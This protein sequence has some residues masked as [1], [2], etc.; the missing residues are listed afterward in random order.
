MSFFRRNSK[1][2]IP[3]T[4]KNADIYARFDQK[5]KAPVSDLAD[6]YSRE[7]RGQKANLPSDVNFTVTQSDLQTFADEAYNKEF[8]AFLTG[9]HHLSPFQHY[10]TL[11]DVRQYV[12]SRMKPVLDD[13]IKRHMLKEFKP[14]NLADCYAYFRMLKEE[15]KGS[16]ETPALMGKHGFLPPDFS[17]MGLYKTDTTPLDVENQ[18][19][20]KLD[21]LSNV[22]ERVR[23]Q[24]VAGIVANNVEKY[25]SQVFEE[26]HRQTGLEPI[27]VS[28][29]KANVVKRFFPQKEDQAEVLQIAKEID[30]RSEPAVEPIQDPLSMTDFK[31]EQ[32][33]TAFASI[34]IEPLSTPAFEFSPLTYP[35]ADIS[36]ESPVTLAEAK[37]SL[38]TM[39]DTPLP[40]V[41]KTEKE[42]QVLQ[43][44]NR[45][46]ENVKTPSV[47]TDILI[48]QQQFQKTTP[49]YQTPSEAKIP[50]AEPLS[51][52]LE[53]LIERMGIEDLTSAFEDS[54]NAAKQLN[55]EDE[56]DEEIPQAATTE[57]GVQT[58]QKYVKYAA[59][60]DKWDEMVYRALLPR[61]AKKSSVDE[62]LQQTTPGL[63]LNVQL[64]KLRANKNGEQRLLRNIVEKAAKERN[65]LA[66][67][68]RWNQIQ[69]T[70]EVELGYPIQ[71]TADGMFVI[72]FNKQ[73]K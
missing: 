7:L 54:A 62:T 14:S 38:S 60:M 72:N 21:S 9:K 61:E 12:L 19:Q 66:S 57:T 11:P 18:V 8:I 29:A 25:F 71:K 31:E 64:Q 36:Q 52:E 23:K 30:P 22:S 50:V 20:N 49:G 40:L 32:Q 24:V 43:V 35:D 2:P 16:K 47:Q 65:I 13:T 37:Q 1:P 48:Q 33:D 26:E 15:S 46:V 63:R 5:V 58:P 4:V 45:L 67:A 27:L 53:K 56:Q 28:K 34:K 3:Q 42:S 69:K 44:Y 6:L 41:P 73:I 55:F 17:K 39:K 59:I 70:F 51:V 68:I 10:M